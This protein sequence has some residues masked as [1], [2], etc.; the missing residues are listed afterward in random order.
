MGE[1]EGWKDE[2]ER[3]PREEPEGGA[4][5]GSRWN[6]LIYVVL[7]FLLGVIG[8]LTYGL[9]SQGG[10]RAQQAPSPESIVLTV[11]QEKIY[12]AAMTEYLCPCGSCELVFI[13]CHCPT[14]QQT[15]LAVRET[16]KRGASERDIARLL[17]ET[18]QAERLR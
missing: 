1:S 17:E 6:F 2:R 10:R 13:D 8:I 12:L 11:P 18:F 9:Y 7:I 3:E 5:G 14:A 16:L 15:K 4:S